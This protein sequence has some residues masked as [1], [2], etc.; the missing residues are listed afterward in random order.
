MGNQV[1]RFVNYWT[2][3]TQLVFQGSTQMGMTLRKC[4]M[5]A[6]QQLREQTQSHTPAIPDYLRSTMDAG[7]GY[8]VASL[9]ASQRFA[10]DSADAVLDATEDQNS[11]GRR[12]YAKSGPQAHEHNGRHSG[13]DAAA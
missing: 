12:K 5:H 13:G 10:V 4:G 11:D 3:L 8:A 9:D 1:S 2:G 6:T 7:M